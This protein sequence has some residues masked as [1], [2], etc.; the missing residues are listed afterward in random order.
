VWTAFLFCPPFSQ[1]RRYERKSTEPK[2]R[3]LDH[4]AAETQ[5]E[6]HRAMADFALQR[7]LGAIWQ[8][9]AATNKYIVQ[10]EPWVLAKQAKETGDP[11]AGARLATSL[12]VMAESLRLIAQALA[13]FLPDTAAAVAQQ[14]GSELAQ[15]GEWCDALSWGKLAAGT[16][17]QSAAVLFLKR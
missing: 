14:V 4:L 11:S 8:L 12:Y 13:P 16:P 7:A 10:V 9:V 2:R 17:V 3:T 1:E 5:K 6:L 15:P